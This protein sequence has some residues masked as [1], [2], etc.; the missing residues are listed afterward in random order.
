MKGQAA[1]LEVYGA[2]TDVRWTYVSPPPGHFAP[3]ERT[4]KYR[5]GLD[6]P[7]VASDGS[8][9]LS[10][11]DYAVAIVDEIEHPRFIGKRFTVGY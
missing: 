7:V 6:H 4:G 3:G 8:M 9:R 2:S 10:Y 11:E 1:A 5:T